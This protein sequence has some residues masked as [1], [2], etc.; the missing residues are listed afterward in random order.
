MNNLNS[1]KPDAIN[2]YSKIYFLYLLL[3]IF[4]VPIIKLVIDIY[5]I[6]RDHKR[7]QTTIHVNYSNA[8]ENPYEEE[9]LLRSIHDKLCVNNLGLE[10]LTKEELQ[11][12]KK[13]HLL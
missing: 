4:I 9:N 8:S 1:A 12:L 6:V 10:S 11:I 3:I 7:K 13:H 2:Q 5:H